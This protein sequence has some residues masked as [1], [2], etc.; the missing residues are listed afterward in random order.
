MDV[1]LF[2]TELFEHTL[3][4][5]IYG[6]ESRFRDLAELI[7]TKTLVTFSNYIPCVYTSVLNLNDPNAYVREE[8]GRIGREYYIN[9]YVLDK[10]K[11]NIMDLLN[12]DYS[13]GTQFDPE[14]EYYWSSMIAPRQHIDLETML[15]G[16]EAT[17]TKTLADSAFPYKRYA[18]LRGARTVYLKNYPDTGMVELRLRVNFP[19]IASIPEGYREVFIQLA[20]YDVKIKLYNELKYIETVVT[21]AG[22]LDLKISDWDS[23]ER[24]RIDFLKELRSKSFPDRIRDDYFRLL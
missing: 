23:A 10:F 11:L 5:D 9:D 14:G 18:E 4:L 21:P 24:D 16:A 20:E 3:G 8:Y 2:Y 19:N 15:L 1:N 12:V 6:L 22:N 7:N 13:T 17:Y